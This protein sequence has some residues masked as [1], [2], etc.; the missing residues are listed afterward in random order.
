MEERLIHQIK[1]RLPVM[2]KSAEKNRKAAIRLFCLECMGGSIED[3]KICDCHDCTLWPFRLGSC[4]RPKQGLQA[5]KN[6][7]LCKEAT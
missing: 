6:D 4:A 1:R 2:A 7:V 3:V 5:S